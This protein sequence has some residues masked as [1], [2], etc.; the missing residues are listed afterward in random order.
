MGD[1]V[2]TAEPF[3]G[4]YKRSYEAVKLREIYDVAVV[5]AA[6][7]LGKETAAQNAVKAAFGATMP[8]VGISVLSKDEN[9]RL[10]RLGLDQ[11]FI[12]FPRAQKDAGAEPHISKILGGVFYTTDQSDVWV[13]LELCGMG[14]R[15]ALERICPLD[16][17]PK[18]F[19]VGAAARTMMEHLGTIIIQNDTDSFLLLSASSSAQSFLHALETS[20]I[21][22]A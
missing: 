13:M 8:K 19:G 10:V 7:P 9:L 5:S 6:I 4:R 11:L 18:S 22:T 17:M 21:N 2:L 12:M 1:Y 16:L 3:L 15:R 14:A 20:I